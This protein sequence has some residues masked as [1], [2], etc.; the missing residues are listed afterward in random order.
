MRQLLVLDL[1]SESSSS[2]AWASAAFVQ[3]SSWVMESAWD[4]VVVA[5]LADWAA[6]SFRDSEGDLVAVASS[7]CAEAVAGF[8]PI[9]RIH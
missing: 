7:D 3:S 2:A 6:A 4:V 5:E 1:E 8:G 9:R